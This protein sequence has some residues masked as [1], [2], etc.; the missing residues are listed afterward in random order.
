MQEW[1]TRAVRT[2]PAGMPGYLAYKKKI[3]SL[4]PPLGPRASTKKHKTSSLTLT[5]N[6]QTLEPQTLNSKLKILDPDPP[7]PRP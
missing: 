7:D 1:T 2:F 3:P 4:G 5:P 6:S